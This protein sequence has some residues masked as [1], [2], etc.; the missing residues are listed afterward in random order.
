MSAAYGTQVASLLDLHENSRPVYKV[1]EDDNQHKPLWQD[2]ALGILTAML[3]LAVLVTVGSLLY[4]LGP[5]TV[6]ANLIVS[7]G[8]FDVLP[9]CCLFAIFI[10]GISAGL[11]HYLRERADTTST[12]IRRPLG[13]LVAMGA[14]ASFLPGL[15]I[16]GLTWWAARAVL[17]ESPHLVTVLLVLGGIPLTSGLTGGAVAFVAGLRASWVPSY[18]RQRAYLLIFGCLVSLFMLAV[19]AETL[20]G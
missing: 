1:M 13:R 12:G 10:G 16:G 7:S 17:A 3:T 14:A 18:T 6:L 9:V 4:G 15:L 20:R 5:A 8:L 2:L 19:L 11:V